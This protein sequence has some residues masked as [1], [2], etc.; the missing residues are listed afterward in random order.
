MVAEQFTEFKTLQFEGREVANPTGQHLESSITQLVVGYNLTS[1]VALQISV[2][3]I[4]RSFERPEGFAMDRGT[5]SGLGDVSLVADAVVFLLEPH[6]SDLALSVSLLGG[7]KSPTG[8]TDRLKEEFNEIEVP[9]APQSGIHGH[10][11]TLGSGSFDGIF[12]AQ[13]AVRYRRFFF[14]AGGFYYLRSE[15]AHGYEYADGVIGFGGP[16]VHFVRRQHRQ[17]SLQ[18]LIS[19]EH[20]GRDR[21]RGELAEDTGNT[22]VYLGPRVL[23]SL[24]KV[25]AEL[26]GE[27]PVSID[28]TALQAV[29]N[30]RLRARFVLQF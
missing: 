24:G 20:K 19:G 8:A 17:L 10:D 11:L 12:G 29:P 18:F 26:G 3:F 13:T 15:G 25:S 6:E 16:G 28:N 5:E 7:V 21:F 14:E 30:Y 1:R 27:I 9:A 4:Y 22:S 2:P 23:I